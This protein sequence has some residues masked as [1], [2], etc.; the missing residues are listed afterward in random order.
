MG[1]GGGE[2][3]EANRSNHVKFLGSKVKEVFFIIIILRALCSKRLKYYSDL[4]DW[5]P[6]RETGGPFS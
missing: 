3:G 6:G 4:K 1:V 2:G 5:N